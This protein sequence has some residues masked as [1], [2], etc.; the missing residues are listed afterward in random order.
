MW[1]TVL[2]VALYGLAA[3]GAI[4]VVGVGGVLIFVG[5]FFTDG[6]NGGL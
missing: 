6:P 1:D 5:F 3:V 4:A 2:H